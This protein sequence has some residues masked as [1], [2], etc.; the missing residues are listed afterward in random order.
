MLEV[1][2]GVKWKG[3]SSS[4]QARQ[5]CNNS[6]MFNPIKTTHVGMWAIILVW[7]IAFLRG[8]VCMH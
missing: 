7:G 2:L 5:A 8:N 4:M 3:C 6:N 1:G